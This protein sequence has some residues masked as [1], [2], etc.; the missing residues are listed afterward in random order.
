MVFFHGFSIV[1]VPGYHWR[2]MLCERCTVKAPSSLKPCG[3]RGSRWEQ[4]WDS[5]DLNHKW[6]FDGGFH[7][8]LMG[9]QWDLTGKF[10]MDWA[11][12]GIYTI[13]MG[14][15]GDLLRFHGIYYVLHGDILNGFHSHGGPPIDPIAAWFISG[16]ILWNMDDNYG[17]PYFK[18]PLYDQRE[19]Q[20]PNME[21]PTI[22]PMQGLCKGIY[23]KKY[24]LLTGVGKCPFLGILHITFKYVLKINP[25]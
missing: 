10:T 8:D 12:D 4:R 23:P 9:I 13:F 7:G 2:F 14:F 17:Y 11:F 3:S 24:G 16:K 19:F 22:R 25:R 15:N 18:K 20:E 1:S 6:G 5:P 21:V